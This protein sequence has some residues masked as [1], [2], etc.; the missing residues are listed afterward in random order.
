MLPDELRYY[1]KA[2]TPLVW[3]QT[4]EEARYTELIRQAYP[5]QVH[6]WN[7]AEGLIGSGRNSQSAPVN[8]LEH[9]CD[10]DSPKGIYLLHD[11]QHYI[12]NPNVIRLLLGFSDAARRNGSKSIVFI[13]PEMT[14]P[15]ELAKELVVY[16][17]GLP[18]SREIYAY[19]T[20]SVDYMV[21]SGIIT[22]GFARRRELLRTI[23]HLKGL[24]LNQI[25]DVLAYSVL[26]HGRI[27]P[28]EVL[29][30]K[31][32]RLSHE[33]VIEIKDWRQCPSFAQIGGLQR[34]KR[35]LTDRKTVFLDASTRQSYRLPLPKGVLLTGVQGNGKSFI[36][37][38]CAR[39]WKLPLISLE[40][41]RVFHSRV[42]ASEA[43][44]RKALKI[45]E[46]MQPALLFIDEFEKGFSGVQS[47]GLSD[48]GTASRVFGTF[49]TWLQ[50]HRSQVFVIATSNE[51]SVIP[52]EVMRKGRFDEIFFIDLPTPYERTQ[53]FTLYLKQHKLYHLLPLAERCAAQCRGYTA[54]EI[55][56]V[57]VN[58][59]YM[60]IARN[61][62][63]DKQMLEANLKDLIS[64]SV[65]RGEE[66]E[67]SRTWA[68]GRCVPASDPEP[69]AAGVSDHN[70]DVGRSEFTDGLDEEQEISGEE[71]ESGSSDPVNNRIVE[72]PNAR[73]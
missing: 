29:R 30:Q 71:A 43:N 3:I 37:Q 22:S 62:E 33:S 15:E 65:T 32:D 55:R 40:L 73:R 35:W 28:E 23:Q 42:G 17:A 59:V 70:K 19:L 5:E 67:R 6:R 25:D 44:L 54:A 47:A 63:A 53:I 61:V 60:A 38:A 52:P 68:R 27:D 58:T 50:E 45:V 64:L 57:V 16:H 10:D 39:E 2:H 18:G 21:Q 31:T 11:F 13:C 20:Q 69:L 34:L 49:L 72:F 7:T 14:V 51:I 1:L 36:A 4:F 41:G 26:K 48:G 66:L 46:S 56:Q 9:I 12:E 8:M 24:T